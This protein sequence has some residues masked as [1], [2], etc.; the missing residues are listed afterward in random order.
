MTKADR[1]ADH[2][3]AQIDAGVYRPGDRLP[4]LRALRT[5]YGV[6]VGTVVK[7]L[8]RLEFEARVAAQNKARFLVL[9][10]PTRRLP[11]ALTPHSATEGSPFEQVIHRFHQILQSTEITTPLAGATLGATYVPSQE[12]RRIEAALHRRRG[13]SLYQYEVSP[14]ALLLRR[15]LAKHISAQGP[16][17]SPDEIVVTNGCLE[18]IHLALRATTRPGDAVVLESPTF[19]GVIK[20]AQGLGLN[21]IEVPVLAETGLDLDRLE[22]V[23]AQQ[24]VAA[25]FV[26]PSFNNPTGAVMSIEARKRLARL[27]TRHA[28][29]IIED[30]IYADLFHSGTR[31]PPIISVA[32]EANVYLCSSVSKSLAPGLRVG[33]LAKRRSALRGHDTALADS[34]F[35]L[36]IA[37]ATQPQYVVAEALVS[38]MFEKHLAQ[39][40]PA[41]R[42]NVARIRATVLEC[43]PPGTRVTEPSGGFLLW[44]EIPEPVSPVWLI[45]SAA[46]E[47]IAIVPGAAFTLSHQAPRFIRISAGQPFTEVLV[48]GIRK[49]GKIVAKQTRTLP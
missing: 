23:L 43:F 30:E 37:T 46:S 48:D 11:Q 42:D 21:I 27:A 9:A 47:G 44:A 2:L 40:R 24:S 28:A 3:R 17:L 7:A 39:L 31:L 4:S 38:G 12:L 8:H 14:G 25:I 20:A 34:K 6:S 26:T 19:Y 10:P 33:W 41:L 29:A 36:S 22:Q 1:I 18:A 45:Q 15:E 16:A 32:P 5:Q 35:Q 49:L 13:S